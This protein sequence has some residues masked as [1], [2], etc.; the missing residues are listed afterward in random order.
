MKKHE[1][2]EQQNLKLKTNQ[3]FVFQLTQNHYGGSGVMIGCVTEGE[4]EHEKES[5]TDRACHFMWNL[6]RLKDEA[7][8]LDK[9]GEFSRVYELISAAE[10][11]AAK[12]YDD[13]R[14]EGDAE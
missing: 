1:K 4:N 5:K 7:D 2:A 8:V 12:A 3:S 14:K 6:S 11:A 13:I 10:L 9:N